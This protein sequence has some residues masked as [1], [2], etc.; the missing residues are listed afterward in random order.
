MNWGRREGGADHRV[1]EEAVGVVRAEV[2]C[3]VESGIRIAAALRR[4]HH[5][6]VGDVAEFERAALD[7]VLRHL[8]A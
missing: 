4:Q 5:V 1:E 8:A 6:T 2:E 3:D 7:G